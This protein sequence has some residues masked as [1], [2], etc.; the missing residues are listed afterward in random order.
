MPIEFHPVLPFF[1][2]GTPERVNYLFV[3]FVL[4]VVV[5]SC[6]CI[7]FIIAVVFQLHEIDGPAFG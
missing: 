4:V 7:I 5:G 3:I 2:F 1:Q 6:I